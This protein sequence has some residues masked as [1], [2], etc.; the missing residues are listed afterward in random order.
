MRK[1]QLAVGLGLLLC[2]AT[3]VPALAQPAGGSKDYPAACTSV[4]QAQSDK[5]HDLYK[6]GK[7]QYDDNNWDAAIA[8]FRDAYSRDCTK[9]ELLVIISR[10]YELKGDRAEAIRALETYLERDPKSGEADTYRRRIAKLKEEL[11]KAPPAATG[12]VTPPPPASTGAP[13]P[14]PPAGGESR[15]HTPYPWVVVGIGGAAV[16]AGIVVIA[17]T[18]SF[19][20]GCDKDKGTCTR[21][22]T[23]TD[24]SFKD[25]QEQAGRSQ[26]QPTAGAIVIGAG[27]GIV[28]LGLLWHFLEPTGPAEGSAAKAGPKVTPSVAPG[29]AGLSL[30]SSF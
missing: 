2:A 30:G 11:A 20:A 28:G 25:R 19:P 23:D 17:T 3:T 6:A 10:A 8:T 12:T 1:R 18:P 29:Y 7:V 9:H 22:D 4:S 15:G 27:V 24:A 5:A 14:P 26:D 16:L 13:P 21:L